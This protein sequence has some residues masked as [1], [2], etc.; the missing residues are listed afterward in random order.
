MVVASG[1]SLSTFTLVFVSVPLLPMSSV[2]FTPRVPVA[3]GPVPTELMSH[4]MVNSVP[5]VLF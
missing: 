5:A 3:S 1:S 2:M 4:T